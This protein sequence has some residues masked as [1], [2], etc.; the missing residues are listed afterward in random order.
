MKQMPEPELFKSMP[1]KDDASVDA[2]TKAVRAIVD[3]EAAA[4]IAK[5]ERL[6]AARLAREGIEHPA[7][8][9]HGASRWV[10]YSKAPAS[11]P[12]GG[13]RKRAQPPQPAK[14]DKPTEVPK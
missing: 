5:T 10:A 14:A 4:R 11:D 3:Q 2:T 9:E 6:R 7:S 12:V 8:P 1:S 13:E